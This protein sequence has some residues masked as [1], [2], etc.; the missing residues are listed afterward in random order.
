VVVERAGALAAR[1]GGWAGGWIAP[2]ALLALLGQA[3]GLLGPDPRR[4]SAGATS[5]AAGPGTARARR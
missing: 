5:P 2:E 3:E 4:R 1:H